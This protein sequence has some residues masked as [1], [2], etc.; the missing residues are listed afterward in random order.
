MMFGGPPQKKFFKAAAAG[1]TAALEAFIDGYVPEVCSID[2]RDEKG[3]TALRLA[4]DSG[5][6]E[7]VRLLLSKKANCEAADN[8]TATPLFSAAKNGLSEMAKIL[9]EGGADPNTHSSEYCYPLHWAA[10]NG[11]MDTVRLLIDKGADVNVVTKKDEL[12]PLYYAISQNRGS[13]A[14]LLLASGARADIP[15]ADGKTSAS[16][17]RENN[18]RIYA[19]IQQA[20]AR[21]KAAVAPAAT[22]HPSEG[23]ETWKRL[24]A[25]KA[26]HIGVYPDLNR[27]ITEIFNF[28][29]RERL[30]ITE[31][32]KTGAETVGASEKFDAL[33]DEAI[34]RAT[35]AFKQLGGDVGER[36]TKKSFNL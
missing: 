15:G 36:H 13:V 28:E 25:S 7:T 22:P 2:V 9:L 33:S 4:V 8:E 21:P 14:E 1:D 29:T 34:A 10:Y 35:D 23:S 6:V 20:A 24:G 30:I 17:A 12:T 5:S 18:A 31:N 26:A 16:Y 32:L 11:D 27:K 19:M 3:R